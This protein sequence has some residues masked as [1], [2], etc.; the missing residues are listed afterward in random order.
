MRIS[1]QLKL[2]FG[3]LVQMFAAMRGISLAK[4]AALDETFKVIDPCVSRGALLNTV[5][6]N[7]DQTRI[8]A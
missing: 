7:V 3:I 6:H 5:K 8:T 2:G 4:I 1:T